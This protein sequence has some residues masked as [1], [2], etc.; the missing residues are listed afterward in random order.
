MKITKEKI[1]EE[2]IS[3][4]QKKKREEIENDTTPIYFSYERVIDIDCKIEKT[5]I[6]HETPKI[7]QIEKEEKQQQFTESEDLKKY[8]DS[9]FKQDF[10]DFESDVENEELDL[11]E[12]DNNENEAKQMYFIKKG[13]FEKEKLKQ[14][15]FTLK[16]FL[17][18]DQHQAIMD[19]Q[20]LNKTYTCKFCGELFKSGC[21][22]GGHIS[23]IHS[24]LTKKKKIQ[25]FKKIKKNLK[26]RKVKVI[27]LFE[28]IDLI[29]K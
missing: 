5:Q 4:E 24:G 7:S 26:V 2:I 21:A 20:N 6:L 17:N 9:I 16:S 12:I 3:I 13:I 10:F 28:N 15:Y 25:K 1:S 27:N 8:E 23:K 14:N 22:M 29:Q 11:L 19:A 18:L